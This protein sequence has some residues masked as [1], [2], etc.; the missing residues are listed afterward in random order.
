ML[1]KHKKGDPAVIKPNQKL[2]D[3]KRYFG[4][5]V[6]IGDIYEKSVGLYLSHNKIKKFN[7]AIDNALREEMYYW[8]NH[9]NATDHHTDFNIV[10]FRD[11]YNITEDELP[12]DNLKRWY[13]RERKRLHDRASQ[14]KVYNPQFELFY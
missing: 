10:R 4:F 11:M 1:E 7:T 12:F 9:P 8:C 2:I 5:P 3:D 6:Y 13:Y 14:Q